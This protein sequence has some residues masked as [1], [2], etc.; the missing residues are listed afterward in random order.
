MIDSDDHAGVDRMLAKRQPSRTGA[1]LT[2]FLALVTC[3]GF[4]MFWGWLM[5]VTGQGGLP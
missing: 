1:L 2:V 4:G 5:I 3:V